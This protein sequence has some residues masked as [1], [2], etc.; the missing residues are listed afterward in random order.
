MSQLAKTSIRLQTAKGTDIANYQEHEVDL[1][2]YSKVKLQEQKYP[3]VRRRNNPMSLYNCHGL[4]FASRRA[5][6]QGE[7]LSNIMLDDGYFSVEEKDVLPGDVVIYFDGQT[8]SH[9]GFVVSVRSEGVLQ[10][11]EVCSKWGHSAEFIH[12]VA[13]SP[14]GTFYKF[15]RI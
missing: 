5:W 2:E 13:R 11:I 10:N 3:G 12:H 9:T 8:P 1:S 7:D 6:V 15:F 4:V 14:Y